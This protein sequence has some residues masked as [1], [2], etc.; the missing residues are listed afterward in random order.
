MSVGPLGGLPAAAAGSQLAQSSGS[1]VER[2]Q[3]E[4]NN[5][6]RRA[7]MDAKAKAASGIPAYRRRRDRDRRARRRRTPS[8]GSD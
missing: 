4:T 8:L 3:Q 1:D 5:Q 2:A 6:S 7:A